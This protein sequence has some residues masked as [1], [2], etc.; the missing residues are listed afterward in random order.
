MV[1]AGQVAI[2]LQQ[3]QLLKNQLKER[4]P[5]PR[6]WGG[7]RNSI[8]ASTFTH[9][10]VPQLILMTVTEVRSSF[11]QRL[12]VLIHRSASA[13]SPEVHFWDM[14]R[15]VGE[16]VLYHSQLGLASGESFW[17]HAPEMGT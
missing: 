12:P 1:L 9:T 8:P 4:M 15:D 3:I 17:G 10:G 5:Q 7:W 13:G 14:I 2:T 16:S 11:G 6:Q